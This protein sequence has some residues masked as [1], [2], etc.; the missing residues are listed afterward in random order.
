MRGAPLSPRRV[1]ATPYNSWILELPLGTAVR[2]SPDLGVRTGEEGIEAF[3]VVARNWEE[4]NTFPVYPGD[5]LVLMAVDRR[6]D[7]H[8]DV[9]WAQVLTPQGAVGWVYASYLAAA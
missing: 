1:P 7:R 9:V 8:S 4:G 2:V 5:L 6:V 3:R